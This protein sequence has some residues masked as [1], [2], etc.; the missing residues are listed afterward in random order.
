MISQTWSETPSDQKYRFVMTDQNRK[1]IMTEDKGM[2]GPYLPPGTPVRYD[3]LEEG[4]DYGVVVHC[5]LDDEIQIYDCYV[6]FF[7]N[8]RPT[9]KPPAKPYILR[10]AST[11]LNVTDL[12][13]PIERQP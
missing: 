7:G 10:Y 5:W 11:S 13:Q 9:G 12:N 3:G 2:F 4:Y 1:Q 6:A 8:T